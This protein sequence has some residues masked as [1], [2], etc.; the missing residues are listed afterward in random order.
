MDGFEWNEENQLKNWLKH[1][2]ST[3]E[4]EEVFFNLPLLL[5]DDPRHSQ[6]EPR[7]YVLG[8][9]NHKHRLVC[10][11]YYSYYAARRL[12]TLYLTLGNAQVRQTNNELFI[13]SYELFVSDRFTS[14]YW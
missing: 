8:Q 4:C 10:L 3:A 13:R 12:P 7:H 2:A 5:A 11:F 1:E 6:V 14:R 9:T